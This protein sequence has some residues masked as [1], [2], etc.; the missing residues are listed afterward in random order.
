MGL[1]CRVHGGARVVRR[2]VLDVP[3]QAGRRL[4]CDAREGARGDRDERRAQVQ[5]GRSQHGLLAHGE[6]P[7]P[8]PP[9]D[10][11]HR[12]RP[13]RPQDD[14]R[15]AAAVPAARGRP[16]PNRRAE[17]HGQP[18]RRQHVHRHHRRPAARRC[19]R[20]RVARRR[21]D[22]RQRRRHLHLEGGQWALAPS[23]RWTPA[24]SVPEHE[25]RSDRPLRPRRRVRTRR[26]GVRL[27]L[28][29]EDLA[30]GRSGPRPEGVVGLDEQLVAEGLVGWLISAQRNAADDRGGETDPGG[31]R[32]SGGNGHS[33]SPVVDA[34]GPD[35]KELAPGRLTLHS[36]TECEAARDAYGG[37]RA[38]SSAGSSSSPS[39]SVGAFAVVT[40]YRHG[41]IRPNNPSLQDYPVRGVDVSSFQGAIDWPQLVSAGTLGFAFIKATEGAHTHDAR[42]LQNWTATSGLIARAP[43]HFF[44]F[45]SGGDEQAQNFLRFLP[46]TGELPAGVDIEFA[47]N[48]KHRPSY[49]VIR[50]QLRIFLNDVESVTRRKPII[51]VNG[52]SYARIVQRYFSGYPLWVREVITGPPVGSFPAL[53]FWQY[54]GNGRVA[55]VGKLIDL[56][57]FIGTTKD[58]ERLLRLGH[59]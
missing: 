18:R 28:E 51:Y 15:H 27:R 20:D 49:A 54:A 39:S 25:T 43:Y 9:A 5:G 2:A 13:A 48:C 10:Q 1:Q 23:R 40:L 22:R 3:A 36:V 59:P 32:T 50:Q 58:F 56:D 30:S 12:G 52:A 34:R 57:A 16:R 37:A 11:R 8:P 53:T 24:G 29:G 41:Y 47:G 14:L 17:G 35:H 33:C 31:D 19:A 6:G 44:S 21:P 46:D 45:C 42:F 7:G 26:V 38:A 4:G 55:G